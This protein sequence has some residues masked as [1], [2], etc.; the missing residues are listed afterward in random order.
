MTQPRRTHPLTPLVQAAPSLAFGVIFLLGPGRA[1]LSQRVGPGIPLPVLVLLGSVGLY[2]VVAAVSWASWSRRTYWIDADGDLRVDYGLLQRSSRRL[3]LARLQ[4]V[5][6]VSPLGARAAGGVELRAEVAGATGSRIVL[7]YLTR[8]V[9][10]ELREQIL[11]VARPTGPAGPAASPQPD[12]AESLA[13]VPAG[14][15]LAGLLMRS[16]TAGLL[17]ASV[18]FLTVTVMTEGATGLVLAIVTG[19]VPILS[20]A[21]EFLANYGFRVDRTTDGL[22][23]R[24]G[25]VST[26]VRTI[27]PDR[28]H[29]LGIVEPLLWRRRGW[30]RVTVTVAGAEGDASD[31]GPDLLI[32]VAPRE[33]AL[34]LVAEVLPGVNVE[35]LPFVCA[36][37]QARWRSPLSWRSLAWGGNSEVVASREGR[38]TRRTSVAPHA[39][40]QSVRV[41]EGPWERRLG[42]A[43]LHADIAPGPV[44]IVGRHLPRADVR[45]LADDEASRM[46]EARAGREIPGVS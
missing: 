12:H 45:M 24:R 39:R 14:R 40:V 29:A 1:L 33:E 26:Q 4:R 43:S 32:P 9:A 36:P 16:V 10:E 20:V 25:L 37:E 8:P 13:I 7:R 5:D 6:I 46:R 34:R 2:V 23:I 15:L 22:R 17:I 38:V 28:V 18:V 19:G 30:V 35:G 27:P 41:T 11:S 42:L 31:S 21:G 44:R 3:Q